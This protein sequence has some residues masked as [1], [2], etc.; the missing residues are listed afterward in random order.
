MSAILIKVKPTSHLQT[1][2]QY[3]YVHQVLLLYLKKMR[4]LDDSVNPYL[5]QFTAD[6][7]AA[8]RGFWQAA[9][10]SAICELASSNFAT[11]FAHHSYFSVQTIFVTSKHFRASA[12]TYIY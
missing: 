8:T 6:Y 3:L 7:V 1:E 11:H 10:F 12:C 5:E 9:E 4:Y 2:H